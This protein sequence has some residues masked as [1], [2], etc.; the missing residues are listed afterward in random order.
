MALLIRCL[1]QVRAQQ[2]E[3]A[4]SFAGDRLTRSYWYPANTSFASRS[5]ISQT[6]SAIHK[7]AAPAFADFS[8]PGSGAA[9]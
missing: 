9:R 5:A 6:K 4:V 3:A 8:N 1:Q 7:V 2:G